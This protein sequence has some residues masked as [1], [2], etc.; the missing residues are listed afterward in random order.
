MRIEELATTPFAYLAYLAP[1]L[2]IAGSIWRG[3]AVIWGRFEKKL[4]E[5]TDTA[6]ASATQVKRDLEAKH[7]SN[8]LIQEQIKAQVTATNGTVTVHTGQLAKLEGEVSVLTT[9]F[10]TAMTPKAETLKLP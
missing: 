5:I 2:I 6:A 4:N 1:A 3:V 10:A 9:V 8:L 7:E